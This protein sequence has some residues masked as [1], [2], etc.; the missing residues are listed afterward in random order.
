MGDM[1]TPDFDDLLAAFDIPDIDA[2]E[3]IQSNSGDPDGNRS[4]SSGGKERS[5]G[6]NQRPTSSSEVCESIP[7]ASH[8][9]PAVSVIVKNSVCSDVYISGEDEEDEDM[10]SQVRDVL[11]EVDRSGGGALLSPQLLPRAHSL[12]P[13]D[14]LLYNGFKAVSDG[15]L[16]AS[17]HSTPTP[18]QPNGQLWS[19][20]SPKTASE[21]DEGNQDGGSCNHPAI[22]P[23]HVPLPVSAP[24]TNVIGLLPSK[25]DEDEVG[26][27]S[28]ISS[29]LLDQSLN[30]ISKA[31]VQHPLCE[32]EESEPDLESPPLM[33]QES[34]DLQMSPHRHES[35]SDFPAASPSYQSLP[36]SKSPVREDTSVPQHLSP[37]GPHQTPTQGN[38]NSTS[39]TEKNDS[40]NAERYPEHIIDER[41]SPES[42]EPETPACLQGRDLMSAATQK[43][44]SPLQLSTSLLTTQLG[45]KVL[46][47][48]S[49]VEV[50]GKKDAVESGGNGQE[51]G[52]G[53]QL[54]KSDEQSKVDVK[55]DTEGAK[56]S[57]SDP[58]PATE[59]STDPS[60][61]PSRPLKVRIKTVKTL[62]GNITRTVTR[63][64]PKGATGGATKGPD[65]AKIQLGARKVLSRPK[66]PAA[67]ISGQPQGAKTPVLPVATLQDASA[68]M[69]FAASKAQ[70]LARPACGGPKAAATPSV[71]SSSESVVTARVLGHKMVRSAGPSGRPVS[72]MNSPGAPV[73]RSQSTLV[74]AFNK[75]L[76]GKNP[77][78]SYQP[79]LSTLPPPEWGLGVPATGYRCLECGDAFALERSL[80]RH[81]DRR[82]L[83]IEVT[84]NHCTKRL[85]FFNKCSLLLHA[86]KHK[87]KGLVMQCSHLVMKPVSVEQMIGQPDTVPV[88]G[89]Q[90]WCPECNSLFSSR[91]ELA[92]HFQHAEPSGVDTC[93]M[94]CSPPMPLWNPCSAAAHQRLHQHLSPLVCPECG[95]ICQP[96]SLSTHT[97]QACLHYARQLGHRC[98]C[99]QVVFGGVNSLNAVKTHMQTAHCEIFHKCPSCPMAFKSASSADAHCTAQ[100]PDLSHTP[101]HSKEIYKCVMCRTLF[102]QKGLLNLHFDTH[103]VKQKVQV[104]KCPDCNK[105]F[106]QR[107]SLLEHVKASH[108]NT[109]VHL[110]DISARRGSV[111]MVGSNGEEWRREDEEEGVGNPGA[112]E[113]PA[114]PDVLIWSCSEC[115]T[116]YTNKDNYISHM[117]TQHRKE[118]KRFPCTQCEGSFS[119][120]SSL[121]RHIRVK[122]K[123]IKRASFYCQLCTEGKKSFS[124]KL[125]LEKHMQIHH[126]GQRGASTPSQVCPR[127]T[128]T[129]D[130]SSEQ[131]GALNTVTAA[132]AEDGSPVKGHPPRS[133]RGGWPQDQEGVGFRCMPCGFI[134]EDKEEFRHHIKSHRGDMG[135]AVQ[136][137]QCGACFASGSSLSRHR[138]ISHR[139]RDADSERSSTPTP[140]PDGDD[141]QSNVTPGPAAR[142]ASPALPPQPED[143]EDKFACKVCR[144][145]FSKAADLN[146]HF[147]TH[148][149]AFLT[150]YK[151]DKPN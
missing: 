15:T 72:I 102:T 120:S 35:S 76:N 64:A 46:G 51:L 145:Q 82:S 108:R 130:S 107:G 123:G 131:D 14:T 129:A 26:H 139:M 126:G 12:L 95:L 70:K 98:D 94:Q 116:R 101:K 20:C 80:A 75:I 41:D 113:S 124:S 140:A 19:L 23:P 49:A 50:P 151:T 106:T 1:K 33:I 128:D 77:L 66:R 148:G 63:V 74:E 146:T 56:S 65:G 24:S 132:S 31:G 60:M 6:P 58:K 137:Q 30:S 34:P 27:P 90:R 52:D 133:L 62:T 96:H 54:M 87:E 105:V 61:V 29:N 73:S 69:L 8:D 92:A 57:R 37:I 22:F 118:L 5:E 89:L 112:M 121:R 53:D 86:R 48:E 104:F 10:V 42:P 40:P 111:K 47:Q 21:G 93:C 85:I 59:N 83:R 79:D 147:R 136:C 103:L 28:P 36:S 110:N 25:V 135:G 88:G 117:A 9:L 144:C 7:L 55:V 122:H 127:S 143:G 68:A 84:C 119:S 43:S 38:S 114:L 13:S 115:Q 97:Q 16:E 44:T 71:S 2:K 32:D 18:M 11:D 125:I 17:L 149:M 142:A 45:E 67:A 150:S 81:Y 91:E 99:C 3:A 78:P 4:E 109:A 138:F 134:S 141:Q 39:M 100:H